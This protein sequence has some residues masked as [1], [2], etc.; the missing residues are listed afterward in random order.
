MLLSKVV[1]E[2][3]ATQ[4]HATHD[5]LKLLLVR[6][7]NR[8][9]AEHG[10]PLVAVDTLDA[11]VGDTVLLTLDGWA[12]MT[13]VKRARAPIDAAVIAIVDSVDWLD[14]EPARGAEKR[15]LD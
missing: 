6:Q 12:A 2:V 9:G 14:A 4:N 11:G 3:V 13:A 5:A 8:A 15:R 10:A 7:T 1:G